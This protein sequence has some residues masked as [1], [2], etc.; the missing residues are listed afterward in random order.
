LRSLATHH[1]GT[2]DTKVTKRIGDTAA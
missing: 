1:E 2:K